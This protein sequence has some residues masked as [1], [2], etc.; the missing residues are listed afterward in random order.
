MKKVEITEIS[1]TETGELLIKPKENKDN[2]FQFIY[3][4]ATGINWDDKKQSFKTPKPKERSYTD[5]YEN[6]IDSVIDEMGEKLEVTS[7]TKYNN[8]PDELITAIINIK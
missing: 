7:E 5:W 3:R 4:T 8:L 6:I 2:F 1:I